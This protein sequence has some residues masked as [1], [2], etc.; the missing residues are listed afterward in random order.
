MRFALKC[1]AQTDLLKGL[2]YIVLSVLVRLADT[3]PKHNG[4]NHNFK[5]FY[6]RIRSLNIF[7]L[8]VHNLKRRGLPFFRCGDHGRNQ[9]LIEFIVHKHH[10][11]PLYIYIYIYIYI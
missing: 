5:T 2:S 9:F 8:L 1:A 4:P 6:F 10:T 11:I 3:V 7:Y